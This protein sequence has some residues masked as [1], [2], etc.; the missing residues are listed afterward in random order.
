IAAAGRE[1]LRASAAPPRA[2]SN[3]SDALAHSLPYAAMLAAF[4]VLAYF[5]RGDISGPATLM[6]MIVFALALLLMVRQAVVLR[7]DALGREQRATRRVEARYA[8]LIANASDVIMIVAADGT[9]RFAS[10]ASERPLGLK[11]EEV[12]GKSLPELWA[13]EDA[14]KLRMFL[15]DVAA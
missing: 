4:L 1:Q 9:V 8:P 7:G 13:G 11:P 12:G 14:E 15:A 10:P 6:T 2:M 5:T 3:T